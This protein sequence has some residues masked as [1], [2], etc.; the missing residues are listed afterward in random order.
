VTQVIQ[1]FELGLKDKSRQV[2]VCAMLSEGKLIQEFDEKS[3]ET[4]KTRAHLLGFLKITQDAFQAED[5]DAIARAVQC[6]VDIASDHAAWFEP[7][8][9]DLAQLCSTMGQSKKMNAGLRNSCLEI[10]VTI[11]ENEDIMARKY[12]NFLKHTS[13]LAM[14]LMLEI[15]DDPDW[16]NRDPATDQGREENTNNEYARM[17][18]DRL[19]VGIGGRKLKPAIFPMISNCVGQKDWRMRQAGLMALSQVAEVMELKELP[20]ERVV[21]YLR[22]P[23]PRVRHAAANCIGQIAN[24]FAPVLQE[25]YHG[26]ILPEL[27]KIIVDSRYPRIQTHASAAMFNFIEECDEKIIEQYVETLVVELVKVLKNGVTTVQEQCLTTIACISGSAPNLFQKY[28]DNVGGLVMQILVHSQRKDQERLRARAMECISYMG[29][30]VGKEK[31]RPYAQRLMG[32]FGQMI[33]RGMGDDDTTKQYMLQAWTR[34]ASVMK[35]EFT[36][37]LKHVVPEVLKVASKRVEFQQGQLNGLTIMGL[38]SSL[39]EKATAC[40]MLCSF[41]HEINEGFFPY[42]QESAKVMLPLMEYYLNDEVRKFAVNIMPDLLTSSIAAVKA[43]KAN[44]NMLF[45]LFRAI[46]LKMLECMSNEPDTEVLQELVQGLNKCISLSKPLGRRCVDNGALEILGKSLLRLLA[47]SQQSLT[48][49]QQQ[50]RRADLDI[51]ASDKLDEKAASEDELSFLAADCIGTLIKSHGTA[52]LNTFE[53][54]GPAILEMAHPSRTALT[55]KYAVFIIDDLVEFIGPAASKYFPQILPPLFKYALDDDPALQQASVYGLGVCAEF[56][57]EGFDKY[58][59]DSL[60]VL[61]NAITKN[62]Q[63]PKANED[64]HSATDNA[65]S[66]FAKTCKTRSKVVNLSKALPA[67]LHWLPLRVDESEAERVYAMFCSLVETNNKHLLGDTMQHLP[68]AVKV[69]VHVCG[70]NMIEKDLSARMARLLLQINTKMP[71]KMLDSLRSTLPGPLKEKMDKI[72]EA[73]KA[74]S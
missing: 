52:F 61:A 54:I 59:N 29:M 66:A 67:F 13:Y 37:Y 6:L 27:L 73:V 25:M 9:E 63:N 7:K 51:E 21:Q 44:E 53:K 19:A 5:E 38:T 48:S 49:I 56:G 4:E 40:S 15:P 23:H 45:Q 41:A 57:G 58:V 33:S 26:M 74:S 42:V 72:V 1:A 30:A 55:R 8:L 24:D 3:K 11:A 28:F 69:L 70:S 32:I 65:I 20:I 64:L 46:T 18:L 36:P 35:Q 62:R 2:R 12:P 60:K 47:K 22:D 39:E 50:R 71:P 31:F 16:V 10:L 34:I 14:K 68:Q 43:G 17:A